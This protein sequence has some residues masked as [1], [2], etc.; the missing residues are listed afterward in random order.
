MALMRAHH[1]NHAQDLNINA[2]LPSFNFNLLIRRGNWIYC[3]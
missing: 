2:Y 1:I 3:L